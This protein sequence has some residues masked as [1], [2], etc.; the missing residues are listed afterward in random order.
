MIFHE[1]YGCYY[2]AVSKII[3]E[4]LNGKLDDKQ[5][6]YIINKY[7]FSESGLII[8]PSLKNEKWQIINKDMKMP[9]KHEP[10]ISLTTIQ[11]RWLKAISL[12]PRIKLFNV[13]TSILEGIEPLFTPNDFILFDKYND[14]DNFEDEKYIKNF[15]TIIKAIHEKRKLRINYATDNSVIY[16]IPVNLEYSEKDDKFRLRGRSKYKNHILN[17]GRIISCEP[18]DSFENNYKI[19]TKNK[20][21][22]FIVEIND[23]R[24]ALERVMIHFSH[25]EKRA[26][27]ID[28]K[29]YRMKVYYEGDDETELVIRVLS[30]GPLI[31]VTEPIR[32]FN[33][34]KERLIM[35]KNCGLK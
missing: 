11:K 13:D 24:N 6:S 19:K 31:K 21:K 12:D 9:I 18:A 27:K 7:A 30:F 25:F 33:L 23:E 35:Q 26:E 34:I 5:M 29:T 2:N 10:K 4:A 32:F 28:D 22:Y 15:Q 16:C 20:D 14:G 1:M 8:I 17:L 3:K